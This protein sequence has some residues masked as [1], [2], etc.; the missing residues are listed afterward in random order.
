MFQKR[1]VVGAG[2]GDIMTVSAQFQQFKCHGRLG[3]NCRL[4][5]R[6]ARG[7]L[8]SYVRLGRGTGVNYG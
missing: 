8:Q 7:S 3:E 6:A 2:K 1:L 4:G 5:I